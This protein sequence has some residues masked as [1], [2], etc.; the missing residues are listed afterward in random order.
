MKNTKEKPAPIPVKKV[1]QPQEW[2][3]AKSEN[4][5]MIMA[6]FFTDQVWF[7]F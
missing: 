3:N 1:E 2:T 7:K 4:K 6:L 5:G